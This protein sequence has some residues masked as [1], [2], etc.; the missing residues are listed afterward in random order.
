MDMWEYSRFG[1]Y[2]KRNLDKAG[3]R[4]IDR[5][6]TMPYLTLMPWTRSAA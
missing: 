6:R 5:H 2:V 3:T 1:G 4:S